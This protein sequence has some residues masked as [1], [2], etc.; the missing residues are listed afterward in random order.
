MII[1][2][3]KGITNLILSFRKTIPGRSWI[4]FTTKEVKQL[5]ITDE[6]ASELRNPK[7]LSTFIL[8]RALAISYY[9]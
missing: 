8:K 5:S 1:K 4:G 6:I 2:I 7:Q 3:L 9:L